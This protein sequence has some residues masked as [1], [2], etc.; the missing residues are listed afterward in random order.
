MLFIVSD[1]W[2]LNY[3]TCE[4]LDRALDSV[5]L[6]KNPAI[7]LFSSQ[8]GSHICHHILFRHPVVLEFCKLSYVAKYSKL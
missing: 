1:L 6:C 2:S 8:S 7:Y 3:V 4:F 5:I